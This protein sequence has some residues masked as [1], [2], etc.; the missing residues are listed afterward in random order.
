M[1]K[2]LF[3]GLVAGLAMAVVGFVLNMLWGETFP[4]LAAEYA[5]ALFRPWSDP[6]MSLMF[7]CP[8]LSGLVMSK[9]WATSGGK[10]CFFSVCLPNPSPN[11]NILGFA[12]VFILMSII[13][14][15][16]TYSCFPMSFLMLVTWCVSMIVQYLIGTWILAKMI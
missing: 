16:M 4:G 15:L 13:G 1:K 9:V 3:S 12:S 6:L 7:V 14:M 8:F 5:T 10:I 11:K 2:V